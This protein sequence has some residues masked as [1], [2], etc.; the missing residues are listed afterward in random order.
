[1][2]TRLLINLCY[3]AFGVIEATFFLWLFFKYQKA[4]ERERRH[5]HFLMEWIKR[6]N[7]NYEKELENA[8]KG[9]RRIK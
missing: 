4:I 8:S 1:M 9:L 3:F 6:M 5:N 7:K 2:N